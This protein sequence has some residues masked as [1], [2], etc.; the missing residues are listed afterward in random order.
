M[1][2]L[3]KRD[4]GPHSWS[5]HLQPL[6]FRPLKGG[7]A[8]RSTLCQQLADDPM[9]VAQFLPDARAARLLLEFHEAGTL[10]TLEPAWV[11][12][13][14]EQGTQEGNFRIGELYRNGKGLPQNDESARRFYREASRWGHRGACFKLGLS[15]YALGDAQQAEGMEWITRPG[16]VRLQRLLFRR[17]F[18]LFQTQEARGP[19]LGM[20]PSGGRFLRGPEERPLWIPAQTYLV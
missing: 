4:R 20:T 2:S 8:R 17:G 5:T 3:P 9:K 6:Q 7:V 16:Q 18:T 14:L 11:E 13:L 19:V 15:V 10:A 1:F 12:P